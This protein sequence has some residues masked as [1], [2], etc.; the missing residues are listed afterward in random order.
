MNKN[1]PNLTRLLICFVLF[2]AG[3]VQAGVSNQAGFDGQ[4][5]TPDGDRQARLL[6]SCRPELDYLNLQLVVWG[7]YPAPQRFD[8]DAFEGPEAAAG[9]SRLT[10]LTVAGEQDK[11]ELRTEIGGW[12]SAEVEG[13]FVFSTNQYSGVRQ[14]LAALASAMGQAEST[15]TWV[16]EGYADRSRKIEARFSFDSAGSKRIRETVAGCVAKA[17]KG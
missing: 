4:A 2:C 7:A 13:A 14:D 6:L 9:N 12:Y 3:R 15:L 16:Q 8:Y 1:H 10:R 11:R 17:K 5:T